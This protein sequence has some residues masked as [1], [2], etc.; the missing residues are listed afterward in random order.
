MLSQLLSSTNKFAAFIEENF[1]LT[2]SEMVAGIQYPRYLHSF[3]ELAISH[4]VKLI[5]ID[6]VLHRV[7]EGA[8]P[9]LNPLPEEASILRARSD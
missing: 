1:Q 7:N 2:H 3:R 5:M 6:G 9:G 4:P 8:P